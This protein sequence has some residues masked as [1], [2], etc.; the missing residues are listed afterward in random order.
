MSQTET[1][2]F[3]GRITGAID[4]GQPIP[5][6]PATTTVVVPPDWSPA[7]S[8]TA[9]RYVAPN[10][11]GKTPSTGPALPGLAPQF[12]TAAVSASIHGGNNYFAGGP[13]NGASG[14]TRRIYVKSDDAL[15][16]LI[17]AGQ[18]GRDTERRPRRQR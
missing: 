7:G 17:D 2:H 14:A 13:G 16:A 18:L 9:V 4:A 1:R 3:L 10:A 8:F 11:R 15:A 5:L 12:P 6:M